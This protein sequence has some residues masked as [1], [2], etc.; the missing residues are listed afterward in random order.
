MYSSNSIITEQSIE[1]IAEI[2]KSWQYIQDI[3]VS[4][5]SYEYQHFFSKDFLD[6][7]QEFWQ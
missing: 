6:C 2:A 1:K 4:L 3:V 5:S 7:I